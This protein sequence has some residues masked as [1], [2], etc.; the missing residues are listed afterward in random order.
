[1]N[2]NYTCASCK[3]TFATAGNWPVYRAVEG[4]NEPWC[5]T[6]SK[7]TEEVVEEIKREIKVSAKAI[8]PD[9]A[10]GI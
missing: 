1:M 3:K 6:C 5:P 4:G 7:K 8:I 10:L 2:K 9:I